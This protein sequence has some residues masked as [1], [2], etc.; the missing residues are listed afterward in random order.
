MHGTLTKDQVLVLN[1]VVLCIMN[2]VRCPADQ[3]A[4][5]FLLQ[6]SESCMQ[7]KTT[8]EMNFNK[9]LPLT[10]LALGLLPSGFC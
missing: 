10:L 1:M 7:V 2:T 4:E 6:L 3:I 5:T 8:Q 9:Q